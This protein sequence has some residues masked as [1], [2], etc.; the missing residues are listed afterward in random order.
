MLHPD[1]NPVPEVDLDPECIPVSVPLRLKVAVLG[2]PVP[3]P[4]PQH[5]QKGVKKIRYP[6][7]KMD[8]KLR[9]LI[10]RLHLS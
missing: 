9:Y 4:V 10:T 5:C 6:F 2:V 3:A 7:Q 8:R 1:P